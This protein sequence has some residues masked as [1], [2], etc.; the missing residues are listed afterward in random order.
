[1]T[2]SF[3]TAG[4]SHCVRTSAAQ[5]NPFATAFT[6]RQPPA[7]ILRGGGDPVG[8]EEAGE[9]GGRGGGGGGARGGG[10]GGG[11][12]RG[13]GRPASSRASSSRT[14]GRRR[15]ASGPR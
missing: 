4:V 10:G 12:G 8:L 9:E 11:R 15:P 7:P 5:R 14:P 3:T 6:T 13:S 2:A 1:M